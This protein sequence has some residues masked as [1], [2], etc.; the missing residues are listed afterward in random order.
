VESNDRVIAG[1]AM[2]TIVTSRN[3][4]KVASE[5]TARTAPGRW[6]PMRNAA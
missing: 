2:L 4:R 6:V 5:Q 1:K 3:A